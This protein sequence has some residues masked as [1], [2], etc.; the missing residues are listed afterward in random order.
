MIARTILVLV[1]ACAIAACSDNPSN[2]PNEDAPPMCK[3]PIGFTFAAIGDRSFASFG[4]SGTVHNIRVPDGTPFGVTVKSCDGCDGVCSFEGP[5]PPNNPVDRRRCLN[6]MSVSCQQDSQCPDDGTPYRKCVFIYDAP[7]ATPLVGA[8]GKRGACGW[9][10]IPIAPD[11]MPPTVTGTIDQV[12]GELNLSSLTIFLPLNG[13]G[14]TYR[15]ACSE[16]IGDDVGNDGIKNGRCMPT[17]RGEASDPSLDIGLPC[18]IHRYGSVPG[19]EGNYSMDCAPTVRTT[20][21]S[22]N[23]FGGLFTSSGYQINVTASSPDCTDPNFAGQKCFCGACPDGLTSCLGDAE[24]TGIG[25]GKCGYLPPGCDPNPYPFTNAGTLDPGYN[26]AFAPNQCRAAGTTAHVTTSGN[27]CRDGVCNWN[28]DTGLGSCTSRLTNGTVGCYPHGLGTS[29]VALGGAR[30][31]GSVFI[32]DTATARCNR[33]TPS[34][35]V[36]AQVGLP[37][38]TFQKRSFRIIPEYPE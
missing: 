10:Y 35:V 27:S 37:G 16:C 18:D 4:A 22:P 11:G 1:V 8:M 20:D 6:R 28:A 31:V 36:N 25:N 33:I 17:T 30:K 29:I 19:F 34:P 32:A 14:G 21:G 15:G 9:S 2:K 38:I 3:P 23:V 12:S 5:T 13:Q 7:A 26:P 24:C